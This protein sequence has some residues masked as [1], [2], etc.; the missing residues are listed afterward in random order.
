M[1][2]KELRQLVID[3]LEYDP[4]IEAAH[5]GVAAKDGVV[6]LTGYVGDYAQKHAAE[7]AA[8]RVKGVRAI[9]EELTIRLPGDKK[10]ND[11]EI[12]GRAVN[13]LEWNTV[14]PRDSVR[15]EVSHG[16]VTL[17][18]QVDWNYQRDVAER[19][20]RL[21]SGVTGVSNLIDIA[22]RANALDVKVRIMD[23][24]KRHAEVE[25][26]RIRVEVRDGGTVRLEGEVDTWDER[27]AAEFAAWA[28][29]GVRKVEDHLL[30]A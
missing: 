12:A 1:N 4:S 23:A 3:E 10:T 20:V 27:R 11:D 26:A 5:I 30:I 28:A 2:D 7:C 6:T 29:P 9:A 18:G 21:L 13:I 14:V 15:V 25:A 8:W 19:S 17:T 22:P 16:R 24:L